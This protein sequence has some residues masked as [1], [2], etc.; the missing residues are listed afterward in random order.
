MVAVETTAIQVSGLKIIF[1]TSEMIIYSSVK[2]VFIQ[3]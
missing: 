2:I 1:C 3:A